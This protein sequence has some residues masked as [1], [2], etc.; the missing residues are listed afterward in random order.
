[1]NIL[2]RWVISAAAVLISA[3]ALP[4][5]YIEN[6]GTALLVAAVIAVLNVLLKPLLILLTIPFTIITLGLFLFVIN[7]LI[8]LISSTIVNGFWV[9]GFW[10]ALAFSLILTILSSLF[11]LNRREREQN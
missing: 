11:G 7:A 4:G 8:I 1:M 9:D 6:F 2:L 3:Y 5:V 10:W